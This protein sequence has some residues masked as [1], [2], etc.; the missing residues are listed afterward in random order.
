MGEH[1]PLPTTSAS[2]EQLRTRL[3]RELLLTA[4][5]DTSGFLTVTEIRRA[6]IADLIIVTLH[7]EVPTYPV[8]PIQRA[9]PCLLYTSPSPRD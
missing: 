7:P 6:A 8:H 1:F 4:A 3:G 2:P 5:A 9:E